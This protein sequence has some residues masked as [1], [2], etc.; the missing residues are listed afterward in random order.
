MNELLILVNNIILAD[1]R[2]LSNNIENFRQG[3]QIMFNVNG[4]SYYL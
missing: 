2:Q 4:L 3:F 1:Y